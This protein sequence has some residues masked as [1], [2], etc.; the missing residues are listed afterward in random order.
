MPNITDL[1]NKTEE[2]IFKKSGLL[3]DSR[4]HINNISGLHLQNKLQANL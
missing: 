4:R 1:K 3:S 2:E